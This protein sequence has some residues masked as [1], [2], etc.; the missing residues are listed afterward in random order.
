MTLVGLFNGAAVAF[1]LGDVHCPEPT[2]ITARMAEDLQLQGT[3]VFLSDNGEKKEHYAIVDVRG[4][5]TPIIV[6]VDKLN[7]LELDEQLSQQAE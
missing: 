1:Q 5:A 4:L 6:P 3:I 7:R 2:E